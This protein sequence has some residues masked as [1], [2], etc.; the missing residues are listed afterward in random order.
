MAFNPDKLF[1]LQLAT[2]LLDNQ[3]VTRWTVLL[4]ANR[5]KGRDAEYRGYDASASCQPGRQRGTKASIPTLHGGHLGH[6]YGS[7]PE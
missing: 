1:L 2:L 3:A 4:R 6:L 5:P 7:P